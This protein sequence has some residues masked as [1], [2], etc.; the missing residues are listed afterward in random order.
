VFLLWF[1]HISSSYQTAR[2]TQSGREL[3]T[4]FPAGLSLSSH[5]HILSY[6]TILPYCSLNLRH[7]FT[8]KMVVTRMSHW[9]V[10]KFPFCLL[11]QA[12]IWTWVLTSLMSGAPLPLLVPVPHWVLLCIRGPQPDSPAGWIFLQIKLSIGTWWDLLVVQGMHSDD[13]GGDNSP[14]LQSQMSIQEMLQEFASWDMGLLR[15]LAGSNAL[16]CQHRLSRL[17]SKGWALRTKGSHLIYP[18]KQVT[19]A[20]SKI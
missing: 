18:C 2:Q 8:P 3:L 15:Q 17:M 9:E 19:E 14:S 7:G 6:G 11:G 13:K 5:F 4:C 10:I 1:P 20:K 16:L 12:W